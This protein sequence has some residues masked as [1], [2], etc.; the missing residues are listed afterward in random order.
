VDIN[1][2]VKLEIKILWD[3]ILLYRKIPNLFTEEQIGVYSHHWC[4]YKG[5][6]RFKRGYSGISKKVNAAVSATEFA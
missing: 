5:D 6:R 2:F 3:L 1:D 4:D